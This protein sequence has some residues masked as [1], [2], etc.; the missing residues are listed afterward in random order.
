M[1]LKPVLRD[2]DI[3]TWTQYKIAFKLISPL[4]TGYRK[5]G[6][7]MQTRKYVPAKN[8]WASLTAR[9]TR[10]SG[11]G[12][13]GTEYRRV[14]CDIKN[15]F[16]FSYL[17]PALFS[18]KTPEKRDVNWDDL[19]TYFPFQMKE[20]MKSLFNTSIFPEPEE[21]D[22]SNFDYLFS[23]SY[24]GTAINQQNE[25]AY[26]GSLHDIE[27]LAP[28]TRGTKEPVYLTGSIWVKEDNL[29]EY[30]KIWKDC[31]KKIRLGGELR[32]G[33]GRVLPIDCKPF[34]DQINT[35]PVDPEVSWS[36]PIPA[37]L[38]IKAGENNVTGAIEPLVGFKTQEDGKQKIEMESISYV[39]GSFIKV[40][41]A[42]FTIYDS[43]LW[44]YK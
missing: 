6:N 41:N 42:K 10:D 9:I 32:Y 39:P 44:E 23:G 11:K 1:A 17:W 20:G 5:V 33:W 43:G 35:S 16:R 2:S 30:L 18:K 8:L 21:M 25:A 24:T 28:C 36:G 34:G 40:N 4:H 22:I 14:G 29:P 7:L 37:H 15:H 27:F 31:I 26:E 12:A 13:N 38:V 19:K 3:M